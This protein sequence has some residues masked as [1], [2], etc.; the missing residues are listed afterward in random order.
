MPVGDLVQLRDANTVPIRRRLLGHNVHRHLGEIQIRSDAH[1]RGDPGDFQHLPDHGAGHDMGRADALVPRLL[2]IP[3][4]IAGAIDKSLVD[5]VDVDVL[6]R[7]MVQV[8]REDQRGDALILR[9]AGRR[10]IE[11]GLGAVGRVVEPDR[12]LGFEEAGPG[13]DADR[14]QRRRDGQADRLIRAGLVRHQQPGPER[15]E[16]PRNALHRGIVAFE[17]DADITALF[18]RACHVSATLSLKRIS[19][20]IILSK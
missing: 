20:S 13:G 4:K 19:D 2:G 9:H 18:R 15:I 16:S 11:L 8:D 5:A 10:D 17:I 12:L 3:G 6:R 1:G 7:H 14:L